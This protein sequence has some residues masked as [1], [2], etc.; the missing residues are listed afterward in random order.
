[1]IF[2]EDVDYSVHSKEIAQRLLIV[3]PD[4][5]YISDFQ[6]SL[7]SRF[8]VDIQS[9][10]YGIICRDRPCC[11]WRCASLPNYFGLLL[12]LLLLMGL[13]CSYSYSHCSAHCF[14]VVVVVVCFV[15]LFLCH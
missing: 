8:L 6:L 5:S 2:K 10:S 15:G 12:L 7:I 1:V 3:F 11:P 4:L 13:T 14:I 9:V